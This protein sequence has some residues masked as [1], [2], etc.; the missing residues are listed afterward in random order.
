M[1]GHHII[2]QVNAFLLFKF[3]SKKIDDFLI[4]VITPKMGVA[5]RRLYFEDAV[6]ELKNR[7]IKRSATQVEYG[8]FFVFIFCV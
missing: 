1:Q 6:S 2:S 3:I 7:N 4:K 5:V 8:D